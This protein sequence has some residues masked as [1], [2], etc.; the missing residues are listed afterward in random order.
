MQ[1]RQNQR[2]LLSKPLRQRTFGPAVPFPTNR[3]T[4]R[5][6]A[7]CVFACVYILC[8][9]CLDLQISQEQPALESCEVMQRV[10]R[11]E[12]FLEYHIC[13]DSWGAHISTCTLH[14]DDTSVYME[15]IKYTVLTNWLFPHTSYILYINVCIVLLWYSRLHPNLC[16]RQCSWTSALQLFPA[17]APPERA[18]AVLLAAWPRPLATYQNT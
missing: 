2:W 4:S 1:R 6:L 16:S 8:S 12:K 13:W 7:V 15:E 14:F 10:T 5:L 18:P 9:S 11:G 3:R 17:S